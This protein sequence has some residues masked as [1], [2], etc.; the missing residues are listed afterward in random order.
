MGGEYLGEA[1][2]CRARG[3]NEISHGC[4]TPG[5]PTNQDART[6]GKG[7]RTFGSRDKLSM[8]GRETRTSATTV[9]NPEQS[10]TT[11]EY[12]RRQS[13]IRAMFD[14]IRDRRRDWRLSPRNLGNY[15]LKSAIMATIIFC[16]N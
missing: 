15:V 14:D 6:I 12:L 11:V 3:G 5:P 9:V 13:L 10:P 16:T 1:Q 8:V 2:E 4:G 7:F